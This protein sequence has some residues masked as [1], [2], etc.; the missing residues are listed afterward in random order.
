M[1]YE[2]ILFDLDGTLT[3]PA[4][5]ITN[6]LIYA[7]KKYNIEVKDRRELYCCIGPPLIGSFEKIWGFD[8]KKTE[9]AVGFYREYFAVKGIFENEVYEGIPQLLERLTQSG[10]KLYL[11]TSKPEEYACQILE[12]FNLDS[13][14]TFVAGNTLEESR[15]TKYEVL[16][17]LKEQI[18][19]ITAQNS[20]MVGDTK[21][22]ALGA[23][24]AGLDCIGVLYGYG[25][26]E[27]FA[28]AGV[29]RTVNSVA[30]LEKILLKGAY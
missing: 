10:K 25:S 21:Y 9:Q 3:D 15:P 24:K 29:Q 28:D 11:A 2:H 5:G 4:L 17:F 26:A 18:P 16:S 6:S 27:D 14:F 1:A 8:R 22:D 7:L 20:V 19:E 23:Q 30:E 12:H 13:Y